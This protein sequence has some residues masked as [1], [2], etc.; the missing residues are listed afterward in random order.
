[1]LNTHKPFCCPLLLL[2]SVGMAELGGGG[3]AYGHV[4]DSARLIYSSCHAGGITHSPFCYAVLPHH[5]A[6]RVGRGRR[7]TWERL[8]GT[9]CAIKIVKVRN[10][11]LEM[12]LSFLLCCLAVTPICW[13]KGG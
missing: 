6:W 2:H 5:Q 13:V 9:E 3:E 10:A 4:S 7:T 8:L 11:M 1:M 12:H